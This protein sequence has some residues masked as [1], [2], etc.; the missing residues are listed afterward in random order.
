VCEI[1]FFSFVLLVS[2][3]SGVC[4]IRVYVYVRSNYFICGFFF[5]LLFIFFC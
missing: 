4:A 5:L 1:F 2:F 3:S